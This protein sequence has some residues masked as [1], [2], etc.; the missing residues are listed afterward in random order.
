MHARLLFLTVCLLIF[1][2]VATAQEPTESPDFFATA[3]GLVRGATQ[4]A[5]F[6]AQLNTPEPEEDTFILTA[7]A[8]VRGATLTAEALTGQTAAPITQAADP[9][10]FQLTAT[11]FVRE[12]TQ[13]AGASSATSQ[14]HNNESSDNDEA[15][16]GASIIVGGLVGLLAILGSIAAFITGRGNNTGKR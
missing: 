4:T 12:V 10:D 11:A 14:E 8:L 9:D 13:T 5:Q 7:T 3:T 6:E 2:H 16:G 15:L 1:L